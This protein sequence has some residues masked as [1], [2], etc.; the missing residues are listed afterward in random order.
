MSGQ[1]DY[2]MK[3]V[4]PDIEAYDAFYKKLVSKIDITERL[5]R[6]RHGAHQGDDGAAARL[7]AARP[8]GEAAGM[9]TDRR[10]IRN[11]SMT[12]FASSP[13]IRLTRTRR[14]LPAWTA[15]RRSITLG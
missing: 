12:G 3:V 1:V 4:V 6:L 7:H 8:D 5:L 14:K 15:R 10:Q 9:S 13:V 11:G 2:L